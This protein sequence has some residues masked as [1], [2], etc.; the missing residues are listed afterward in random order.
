MA[1]LGET[2]VTKSYAKGQGKMKPKSIVKNKT[3]KI[4]R[5]SAPGKKTKPVPQTKPKNPSSKNPNFKKPMPLKKPNRRPT[6]SGFLSG[7]VPEKPN[8]VYRKKVQR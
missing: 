7:L 3:T 1:S 4:P 2:F 8:K 6:L 5:P